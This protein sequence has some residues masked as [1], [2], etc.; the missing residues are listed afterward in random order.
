[1]ILS[2]ENV[3]KSYASGFWSR[4]RVVLDDVSLALQPGDAYGLLGA[5]GAGKSTTL[6]ILLGLSRPDRGSG[7][8]LDAPLGDRAARAR[9]GYLPE[10]PTFHDQLTAREFLTFCG[11]LQGMRGQTLRDRATALLERLELGA[12]RDLRLRKMSKGMLQRLGLAQALLGEPE[13]LILDEPMSGLDPQGRKLV[14]DLILEQREAGRT[15]LF[16]T[17]ILSDVELV[18]TRAGILR[19]GKLERELRLDDLGR[20]GA[21]SV[22]VVARG[23][24]ATMRERLEARVAATVR[25]GGSTLFTVAPGLPLHA[26]V[27]EIIAVGGILESVAPRRASLE[28]IYVGA[29]SS[30]PLAKGSSTATPPQPATHTTTGHTAGSVAPA[31]DA[32]RTVA[33]REGR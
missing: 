25:T 12:A 4:R 31:T 15:V 22:E 18:C 2:L 29:T 21:Q 7:T 30:P 13:L 11:Q 16:S 32:R 10:T 27:S 5:N 23:L 20:L 8:L 14:R 1:M 26:L 28:E 6:R 17:H 9:L 33:S 3:R 19:A 24:D